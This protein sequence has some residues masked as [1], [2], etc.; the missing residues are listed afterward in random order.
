MIGIMIFHL[1]IE[2]NIYTNFC[3]KTLSPILIL[4]VF[5]FSIARDSQHDWVVKVLAHCCVSWMVIW[6]TLKVLWLLRIQHIYRSMG[7]KKTTTLFENIESSLTNLTY[8]KIYISIYVERE[9]KYVYYEKHISYVNC[10]LAFMS[11]FFSH[12]LQP[13][14]LSFKTQS[15]PTPS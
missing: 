1:N 4:F 15:Q 6:T 3:S 9:D 13:Q 7:L 14:T 5:H 8:T 10:D 2:I 11:I 12:Y